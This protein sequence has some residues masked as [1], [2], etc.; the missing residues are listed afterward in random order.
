MKSLN[1]LRD[2]F[3]SSRVFGNWKTKPSFPQQPQVLRVL[4]QLLSTR[5]NLAQN[6]L[7]LLDTN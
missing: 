7:V 6:N 4:L 5:R 3:Q 2:Q 1:V